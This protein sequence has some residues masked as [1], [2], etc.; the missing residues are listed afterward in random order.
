MSSARTYTPPDYFRTNLLFCT[1]VHIL[2]CR[3]CLQ[4]STGSRPLL[5]KCGK[6]P[7]AAGSQTVSFL[8]YTVKNFRR[9]INGKTVFHPLINGKKVYEF[10]TY[11]KTLFFPYMPR[12]INGFSVYQ[13]LQQRKKGF[14]IRCKFINP[15][16]LQCSRLLG[17]VKPFLANEQDQNQC[18]NALKNNILRWVE[19]TAIFLSCKERTDHQTT[20]KTWNTSS[21]SE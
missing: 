14:I 20:E 19:C 1:Q 10:A 15:Y 9:I 4:T 11:K 6:H 18:I 21:S 2:A 8:G 17:N 5:A 7:W 13:T 12:V 16:F 3:G